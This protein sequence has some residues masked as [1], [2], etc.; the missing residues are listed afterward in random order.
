MD[1][2]AANDQPSRVDA[3]HGGAI[4][5]E[6]MQALLLAQEVIRRCLEGSNASK[7]AALDKNPQ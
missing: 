4:S 1:T 3:L 5:P 6:E 7:N 2:T